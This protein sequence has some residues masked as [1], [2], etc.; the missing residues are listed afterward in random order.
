MMCHHAEMMSGFI[1]DVVV[2]VPG[3]KVDVLATGG[4]YSSLIDKMS[5]SSKNSRRKMASGLSCSLSGSSALSPSFLGISL[6][7]AKLVSMGGRQGG[8]S[9]SFRNKQADACVAI[10][11]ASSLSASFILASHLWKM[12]FQV[13]PANADI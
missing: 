12:N 11:K 6:S 2:Q 1:F 7:L 5:L 4:S 10:F 3:S 9:R 13:R 8:G